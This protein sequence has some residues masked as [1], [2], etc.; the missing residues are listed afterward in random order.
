MQIAMHRQLNSK[1]EHEKKRQY[2]DRIIN[3]EQ[4]SF[5][6]LIFSST[7]GMGREASMFLKRLATMISEK[8]SEL[9]SHTVGLLRCRIAFALIRAS[10]VCLRG[11]RG[12]RKHQLSHDTVTSEAKI[13]H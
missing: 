3:V 9:Y 13:R 5:T 12:S 10:N 4:G 7:G 8:R 1:F 6:P 2:N 11:S